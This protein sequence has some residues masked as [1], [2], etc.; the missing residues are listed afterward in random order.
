[1]RNKLFIG[2]DNGKHG[3]IAL[4]N[5]EGDILDA[6]KYNELEPTLLYDKLS[7]NIDKYDMYAFVEKPIVVY[8][9]AHQTAPFETVGRH[10]M[11]LEILFYS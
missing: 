9:L 10:K 5:L 4:I 6:F 11:T 3:A 8:G 7:V 2:I 1:M